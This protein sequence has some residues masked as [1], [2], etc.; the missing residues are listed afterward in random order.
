MSHKSWTEQFEAKL[1]GLSEAHQASQST[2]S[3]LAYALAEKRIS[4]EEYL[5]WAMA[6]FRLPRLQD[7]FFSDSPPSKNLYENYASH[8][9]WSAECIPVAEWEG[10]MIVACLEPPMD[11]PAEPPCIFVLAS[12]DSLNSA[13]QSFGVSASNVAATVVL[14][15]AA[16]APESPMGIDLSAPTM[17]VSSA[18]KDSFSFEDLAMGDDDIVAESGEESSE[19]EHSAS[20][21]EGAT[22]EALEGLFDAP[23]VV[24]LQ[25]TPAVVEEGAGSHG[26]G[27]APVPAAK[28]ELKPTVLTP[29]EVKPVASSPAPKLVA[30]VGVPVKAS[31]IPAAV[32]LEDEA[33]GTEEKTVMRA[34]APIDI[35]P[36]PQKGTHPAAAPRVITGGKPTMS[37][38]TSGNY[39]LDK[40][41]KKYTP[42]ITQKVT[43]VMT[44]MKSHFEKAL[45]L[46]IDEKESSLTAF[47][48][49]DNFKEVI[50]KSAPIP[51]QTPSIFNIVAAT[52]KPFHG[53]ISINEVNEKF[54]ED[55]N[56]GM[57]PDHVTIAPVIVGDQLVGMIV[58]LAQKSAFNKATLNFAEKVSNEFSKTLTSLKVA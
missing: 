36:P 43:A 16:V 58:G 7:R 42:E 45:I 13:W 52:Q 24:K 14:K 48:W 18:K 10:S 6:N 57:I 37:A 30:T 35:P 19:G 22:P 34:S 40:W 54:F 53:Y 33:I 17:I 51:L 21:E 39:Q 47:A 27:A 3:L 44:Q 23:T 1:L 38:V 41:K 5:Q 2:L 9:S 4:S 8:Y 28:V 15:S 46:T 49:D 26:Q 11:F 29:N 32:A 31:A 56:F 50:D 20:E 55:W 12:F 25:A